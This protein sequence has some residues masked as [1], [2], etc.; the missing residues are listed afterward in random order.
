MSNS[1]YIFLGGSAPAPRCFRSEAL[2]TSAPGAPQPRLPSLPPAAAFTLRP[3]PR[4]LL[5]G[6]MRPQTPQFT[7]V[8]TKVNRKSAKTKV[9]DSFV[10]SVCIRFD[11]AQP[12][13]FCL[14]ASDLHRVSCPA[15]AVALLK[16]EA[17]LG[18]YNELPAP[19]ATT[20]AP[21][22][23]KKQ[24]STRGAT[25][26][27]RKSPHRL[28]RSRRPAEIQWL[29]GI[30]LAGVRLGKKRGPGCP[31]RRFGYFAA[32]GKVTRA[33]A[34]NLPCQPGGLKKRHSEDPSSDKTPRRLGRRQNPP[35][36]EPAKK[37]P[38]RRSRGR[39]AA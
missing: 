11:T 9:L 30:F 16:G 25:A 6:A 8:R 23:K 27:V 15:S 36:V 34:R 4:C 18:F 1:F 24:P 14:L 38:R 10:Q 32:E 7:F 20:Q 39:T 26:E 31:R 33:G 19:V 17:N 3:G 2:R 21:T 35:P 5:L 28:R 22:R 13:N 29:P 12:L 37:P